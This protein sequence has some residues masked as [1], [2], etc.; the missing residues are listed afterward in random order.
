MN[1]DLNLF[2]QAWTGGG[3]VSEAET[4]HPFD[5]MRDE[6]DFRSECVAEIRL[7]GLCKTAQS[8]TPRWLELSEVIGIGDHENESSD[9]FAL[10]VMEQVSG[11]QN[12]QPRNRLQFGQNWRPLVAAAAGLMIGLCSA[13][14]VW[15][16]ARP[17]ANLM[18]REVLIEGFE[19][20][21]LT[22]ISKFPEQA[23]VWNGN[24]AAIVESETAE[25][26]RFVLQFPPGGNEESESY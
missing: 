6:A 5:R 2:L 20:T 10:K 16:V 4:Q 24:E 11:Q 18:A 19:S 12:Q 17:A 13:S 21:G 23:G 22:I 15:A 9:N 1:S 25:E 26:G 3:D 7:L 8:A 14:I